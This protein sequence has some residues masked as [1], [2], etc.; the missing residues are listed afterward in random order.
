[1][2]DEGVFDHLEARL[3]PDWLGVKCNR[4]LVPAVRE[5]LMQYLGETLPAFSMVT[6]PPIAGPPDAQERVA[7]IRGLSRSKYARHKD[8]VNAELQL[9]YEQYRV[10]AGSLSATRD[11][12]N[13]D[14][15]G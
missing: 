14:Y 3:Y 8:E 2:L 10:G 13:G 12:D 1:M 4:A 6:L 5:F 11:N 15:F 9:R 7:H